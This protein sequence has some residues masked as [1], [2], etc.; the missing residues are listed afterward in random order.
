MLLLPSEDL[1][2]YIIVRS[3]G[4]KVKLYGIPTSIEYYTGIISA[5]YYTIITMP[6]QIDVSDATLTRFW[7]IINGLTDDGW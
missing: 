5:Q 4:R 2:A 1:Y 3:D 7:S 6:S